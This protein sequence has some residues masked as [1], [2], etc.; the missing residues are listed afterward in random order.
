L[1]LTR[2][3]CLCFCGATAL[4]LRAIYTLTLHM[5]ALELSDAYAPPELTPFETCDG[6]AAGRTRQKTTIVMMGQT[7]KRSDSSI[8]GENNL[9]AHYPY[10]LSRYQDCAIVDKIL[11]I[12]H[13]RAADLILPERRSR[14]QVTVDERN[15]MID[16]FNVSEFV[17][18]DSVLFLDDDLSL[19]CNALTG[20]LRNFRAEGGNR[21]LGMDARSFENGRYH[22]KRRAGG[23]YN[24]VIG[25]TFLFPTR[26]LED[27]MANPAIVE[28]IEGERRT[29]D[30]ILLNAVVQKATG[31]PPLV[32][33]GYREEQILWPHSFAPRWNLWIP[34]G[35]SS[36]DPPWKWGYN[37][38]K[39]SWGTTRSACG[40]WALK[41]VGLDNFLWE[42]EAR[43]L[44]E[45]PEIWLGGFRNTC[46]FWRYLFWL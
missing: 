29:C 31:R 24:L 36:M 10:I 30:D 17:C 21:Y 3:F 42:T 32:I 44:D 5:P 18:T 27:F 46:G 6:L 38:S 19:T 7:R 2:V 11:L 20:L 15:R 28:A 39:S 34:S 43:P 4:L 37:F 33:C 25:K 9:E 35:L 16:R 45:A 8:Y 12:W 13:G 41:E 14:I 23:A 26:H 22:L 1:S 40:D